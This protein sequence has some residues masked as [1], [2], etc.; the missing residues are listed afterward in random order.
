MKID[1]MELNLTERG[2]S[3]DYREN[4]ESVNNSSPIKYMMALSETAREQGLCEDLV[5]IGGLGILGNVVGV[6]GVDAI[7]KFRD[8]HDVDVILNRAD[9]C[10]GLGNVFDNP[11]FQR[12]QSIRNKYTIKGSSRDYSGETHNE[13]IDLYVP[14][15]DNAFTD[16]FG[17]KVTVDFFGVPVNVLHPLDALRRKLSIS[18]MNGNEPRLKDREDIYNL[19]AVLEKQGHKPVEVRREIFPGESSDRT[20]TKLLTRIMGGLWETDF[21]G[22]GKVSGRFMKALKK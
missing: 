20:G 17:R 5:F 1:E 15:R 3:G 9:C 11:T 14:G 12:S 16:Y 10:G 2:T 8:I 4:M 21:R 6:Y 7:P 13:E 22:I 19:L 18:C